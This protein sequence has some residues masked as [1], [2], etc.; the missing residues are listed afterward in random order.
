MGVHVRSLYRSF[1]AR[2]ITGAGARGSLADL[3]RPRYETVH[4][5]NGI[6]FDMGAGE[7]VGYVGANGAGKSTTIKLLCGVLRP[8][9][10]TVRVN[11]YDPFR[12]RVRYARTMAVVFG[13]RNQL[14]LDLPAH[15]TY[16]MLRYLYRVPAAEYDRRIGAVREVLEL[17]DFWD[18]PTRELSLGQRMRANIAASLIHRPSVVF[19]DE[20]TVGMDVLAK[21]RMRLMLRRLHEETHTL[22]VLT[23]HDLD[24]IEH[25]CKRII[26]IN[27]GRMLYDG[28]VNDLIARYGSETSVTV[29]LRTLHQAPVVAHA[30]V[31]E[32]GP[33][34]YEITFDSSR[35]SAAAI[36]TQLENRHGVVDLTVASARLD[37]VIRRIYSGDRLA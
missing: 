6:S 28:T 9:S 37:S 23:S 25:L 29:R 21:D 22:I 4:A 31:R 34:R 24:D 13:Q 5:V 14:S 2:R 7:I 36:V 18:A 3:L 35:V 30:K 19:L 8:T 10:G 15:E 11:G 20:P 17:D 1:R 16:A 32:V 12:D 27:R 33:G 26:I